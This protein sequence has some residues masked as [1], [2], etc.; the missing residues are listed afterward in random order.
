MIYRER[1]SNTFLDH[2]E[3]YTKDLGGG[4]VI[5]KD[6]HNNAYDLKKCKLLHALTLWIFLLVSH[7][8]TSKL[9]SK[10]TLPYY[11]TKH[12]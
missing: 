7:K 4:G 1:L 11:F 2:K 12:C 6:H 10:S 3:L 8:F 5:T 9:V